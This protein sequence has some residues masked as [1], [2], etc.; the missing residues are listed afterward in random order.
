MTEHDNILV[1]GPF[2]AYQSVGTQFIGGKHTHNYPVPDTPHTTDHRII[3]DIDFEDLSSSP[4]SD[5]RPKNDFSSISP[6]SNSGNPRGPRA[7]ILFMNEYGR[8]DATRTATEAARVLK[9]IADHHM[10]NLRLDSKATNRLNLLLCSFWLRWKELRFVSAIPQGAALYRFATDQCHLP[11]DVLPRAFT[12]KICEL[13]NAG[14][15]DP[16]IYDNLRAYFPELNTQN[17][18]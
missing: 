1:N 14:K 11:C 7:Q 2:I 9:Y 15:K 4:V 10:G 5:N 18:H 12:S 3:E 16:E 8:E 13:I 6:E 17:S